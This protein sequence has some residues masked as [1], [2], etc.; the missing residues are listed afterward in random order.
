MTFAVDGFAKASKRHSMPG[1][2]WIAAVVCTLITPCMIGIAMSQKLHDWPVNTSS[3][4]L[5]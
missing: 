3:F 4:R 5:W 1:G 2:I